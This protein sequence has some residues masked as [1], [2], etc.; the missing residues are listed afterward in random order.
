MKRSNTLIALATFIAIPLLGAPNIDT[1]NYRIGA[2]FD[3]NQHD[4]DDYAAAPMS[5]ALVAEAG[6]KSKLTH[7]DH[8]NHLGD[9]VASRETIMKNNVNGAINKWGF[10]GG[11]HYNDQS[12]LNAA[13]NNIASEINASSNSNRFYLAC[14][15]PMEVAWRGIDASNSN[16]RKHCTAISHSTWNNK[17]KDTS[18]MSHNWNA[19]KNTGVKTT[20][21]SNQNDTAFKDTKNAWLWLKNKGGKYKWLYNRNKKNQWDASDAGMIWYIIT[22][23][24]DQNASMNDIKS[25]FN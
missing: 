4:K 23:R 11:F 3:G 12:Q 20:M 1:S 15:G 6:V 18:Q 7:I 5:I 10:S 25:V 19:V 13:V 14:G 2:S 9:N 17:H 21:I 16:K 24:G 8:S 22:G